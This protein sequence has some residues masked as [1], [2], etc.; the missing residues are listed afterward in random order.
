[1]LGAQLKKEREKW[2]FNNKLHWR[3]VT[4]IKRELHRYPRSE[5]KYPRK[6]TL[7]KAG[8]QT[9]VEKV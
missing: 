7:S 5:G 4:K 6:D 1:M 3:A 9:T 8:V 2:K